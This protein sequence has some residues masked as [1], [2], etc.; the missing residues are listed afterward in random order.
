MR[1]LL[2]TNIIIHR[3]ASKVVNPDIG[4]LF[5]WL[6]NTKL[7]IT[8]CIHPITVEELNRSKDLETV[9]TINIKI[10]NYYLLK[11]ETPFNGI[12]KQ[13]SDKFDITDNDV[14]DSRILN[15]VFSERVDILIS[16]DKKIHTKAKILNISE[17]V[18]SIDT[19]LEKVTAE[20]PDLVDYKILAVRK[21]FFGEVNLS[22]TFFDSFREDYHDFDKWFRKKSDEISYVCYKDEILS[23]FLFIKV[24]NEDENYSDITPTFIKKRRL[25]IGTFKVVNNGYKIG[26]RFLKI[27]FDNALKQKVNEIY[28]TIF[29]EREEHQ[30][31]IALLEEWGFKYH[32][33]KI[34]QNKEE[35]VYV[36]HFDKNLPAN[37]E[38]PK[39]TFPF[40]SKETNIYIIKIEPQYHTE[41]FP[42]SILTIES[43]KDFIENKPYRN[44]ISK[45]YISHSKDRYLKSGDILVIY[46]KGETTP[47]IYS[48]TVTTICIVENVKNN[49]TSFEEL[50]AI[51]R[52]RTVI[53]EDELKTKYWDKYP[54]YK[55]FVINFL[56]AHSFPTPKP[57]LNDLNILGIIPDITNMPRGFIKMNREH[58]NSLVKFAYKK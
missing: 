16:E 18:F 10:K 21:Q 33:I 17:K 14:C 2:D 28:V 30:R 41:L 32:G 19:F 31:L 3:E 13:V 56:Y 39:Y 6:D 40:L 11:T 12:I 23:A 15:E 22:D 34:T 4:Y 55:P 49:L 20:N 27:I 57:T 26:E 9:K 46:R 44:A 53:S 48:S 36:R 29:D 58:F 38:N 43:P 52:K 24:E 35:K 50:L 51:C 37:I 1:V 42:D 47:K 54:D 25:K 45:V 5:H 8:K 7:K